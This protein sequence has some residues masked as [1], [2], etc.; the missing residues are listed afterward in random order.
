MRPVNPSFDG[1]IVLVLVSSNWP[2]NKKKPQITRINTDFHH[3][4]GPRP[5]L[6][7]KEGAL[8]SQALFWGALFALIIIKNANFFIEFG[9]L[10]D[11]VWGCD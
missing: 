11:I 3:H 8:G 4:L 2:M 9:P 7:D 6:P 10:I 1:T 5:P